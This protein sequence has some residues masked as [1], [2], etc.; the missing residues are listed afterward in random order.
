MKKSL[1]KVIIALV[2]FTVIIAIAQ[3]GMTPYVSD[4]ESDGI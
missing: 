2:L 4:S 3:N 1:I